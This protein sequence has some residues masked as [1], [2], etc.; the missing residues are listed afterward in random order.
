MRY[1]DGQGDYRSLLANELEKRTGEVNLADHKLDTSYSGSVSIGTPAQTFDI[2]LDTGS[3]D[4]WIASSACTSECSSMTTFDGSK[5]STYVGS[6]PKNHQP[7]KRVLTNASRLDTT[8]AIQYGSGNASGTLAQ[9]EVTI[10]GYSV[11]SQTFAS[12]SSITTGLLSDSVSGIMGLSWQSLAYSK[13]MFLVARIQSVRLNE[14]WVATPWWI[15]LAESSAWSQPLFAFYLERYRDVSDATDDE[16]NGGEATFGYLGSSSSQSC[17]GVLTYNAD[18]SMYTGSVT[19]VSVPLNAL[20]WQVPLD[21][22][23]TAPQLY[24]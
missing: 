2:V 14:C 16:S 9:D 4:L 10:G 19:Y 21:S 5:S 23:S 17:L 20:Y 22:M 11:A 3:S 18:S 15:T 6:V 24:I 8:F 7:F 1:N 12:C 13:G